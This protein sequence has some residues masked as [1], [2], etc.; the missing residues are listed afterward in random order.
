[1]N[2]TPIHD[3]LLATHLRDTGMAAVEAAAD[4]RVIAIIDKHIADMNAS[5][6]PWS[7]N[8]LRDRLPTCD[9]H[10]IGARVRAAAMR[11]P[12]EQERVGYVPS[13]LPSTHGHP[14]AV[15]LGAEHVADGAA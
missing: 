5:G 12:L 6:R 1:M 3:A 15:W 10:L 7:A 9:H 8:D 11:R 13:S 2:P 4:P 14:I